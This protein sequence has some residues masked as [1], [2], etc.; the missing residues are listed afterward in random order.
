VFDLRFFTKIFIL[1]QFW[2]RIR[3]FFGFGSSQNIVFFSDSDPQHW[4][5]LGQTLCFSLLRAA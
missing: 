4:Q 5:E 3:A 1:Q 2:I